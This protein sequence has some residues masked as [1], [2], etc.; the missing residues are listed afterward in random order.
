[1]LLSMS[2]Q[3]QK[4]EHKPHKRPEALIK[5]LQISESQ[6]EDF[7]SIMKTQ[8][9]QRMGVHKQYEGSRKEKRQAMKGLHKETLEKLADILTQ[10][11]IEAFNAI[12]AQHH[13]MKRNKSKNSRY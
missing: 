9:E 6:S 7:L 3:A 1:M 11:Q 13:A 8:H 12:T 10:S 4:I 2:V 5:I